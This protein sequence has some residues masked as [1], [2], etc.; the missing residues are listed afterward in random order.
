[1]IKAEISNL[2]EVKKAFALGAKKFQR[3]SLSK[4]IRPGAREFAKAVKARAPQD[5]GVLKRSITIKATKGKAD[6]PGAGY[7]VTM[8]KIY[9]YKGKKVE[10]FYA[11]F[12]HNGTVVNTD[13]RK[14]VHRRRTDFRNTKVRIKPNPYVRDA[15]DAIAPTAAS[16]ILRNIE[17]SL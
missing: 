12:V 2:G 14:R 1:M 6:D 16:K 17:T 5:K 9:L 13:G 11:L 4:V 7:Y 15:F 3:R 10:P 8:K